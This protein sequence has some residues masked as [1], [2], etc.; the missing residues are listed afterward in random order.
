MAAT[1]ELL[2]R[3]RHYTTGVDKVDAEHLAILS[4]ADDL[5]YLTGV[6]LLNALY[7]LG[8]LWDANVLTENQ[9]MDASLY[10]YK[11]DHQQAHAQV[12]KFFHSLPV[13]YGKSPTFKG[14]EIL[15]K[16]LKHID[17]Y[18][19]PMTEYFVKNNAAL[20]EGAGSVIRNQPTPP[21]KE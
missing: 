5:R 8:S 2:A 13:D 15:E 21:L 20:S 18:D 1:A 3:M 12:S 19:M 17:Q 9:M 4:L 6:D 14:S 10:P 16:M 7:H 11:Q